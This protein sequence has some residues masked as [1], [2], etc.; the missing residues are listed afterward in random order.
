MRDLSLHLMDIAQNS[1]TAGATLISIGFTV[2]EASKELVLTLE[3][4][5]CGM[6]ADMVQKVR[7]P[8]TT[9]RTTRK[10]GMGIPLTKENAELTGGCLL[11]ESKK[12][13]GTKLKAVFHYDSIDMKPLGDLAGT[14]AAL[15]IANPETPDFVFACRTPKGESSFDTREI[16]QVLQG[17]RLDEPEVAEWIRQSLKEETE[18]LFGGIL[19]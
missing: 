9:T 19:Q 8:F 14:V 3:D 17:V 16:R 6:D 10:V 5:G 7:S 2:E 4:N 15:V 13:E 12:G 11:L 18:Q 1:I